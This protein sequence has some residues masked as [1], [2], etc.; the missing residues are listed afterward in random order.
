MNARLKTFEDKGV[1]I[2]EYI[3]DA[4]DTFVSLV[5]FENGALGTISSTRFATGMKNKLN[6]KIT[7]V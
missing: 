2:G 5:E 1:K 6:L 3:L 4:N 7:I